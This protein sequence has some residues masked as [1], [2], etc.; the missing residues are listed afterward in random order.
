MREQETDVSALKCAVVCVFVL[1]VVLGEC[2]LVML[3]ACG[4]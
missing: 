4:G 3:L 2:L 1:R